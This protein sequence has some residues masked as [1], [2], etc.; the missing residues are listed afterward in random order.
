VGQDPGVA[1]FVYKANTLW[2]L[3][4]PDQALE[5]TDETLSLAT[6]LAHPFSHAF[7]LHAVALGCQYR[8][9]MQQVADHTAA[10]IAL[11]SERGF[12]QLLTMG[13]FLRGSALAVLG[14]GEEGLRQ[15]RQGLMDW[16]ASGTELFVPYFTTLLAEGYEALQQGE[17][18]LDALK[19]GVEVMARTGEHNWKAEVYRLKGVLLL[20]QAAPDVA[21][22]E[23]CF[24]Q[25]LD[26]SRNQQAKSLELR[27][28]I[29]LARLWQRV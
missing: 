23:N 15:M 11:S 28:A 19:M 18:G 8:K 22:A 29:S 1:C 21:Q 9:E 10:T 4:Y 24:Q 5:S 13:A 16:R 17:E 20:Q 26:V 27:A 6:Q 14:Q 3:G 25:A 7:A 12:T 2:L